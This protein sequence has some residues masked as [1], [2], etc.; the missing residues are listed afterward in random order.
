MEIFWEG[1]IACSTPGS[2]GKVDLINSSEE[3]HELFWQNYQLPIYRRAVYE[4]GERFITEKD[5]IR[6]GHSSEHQTGQ[7]EK[8]IKKKDW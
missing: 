4:A 6:H 7:L 1:R 8:E 3:D 5:V 2:L